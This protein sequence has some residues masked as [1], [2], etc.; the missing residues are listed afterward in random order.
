MKKRKALKLKALESNSR[1][2][3][4]E[5][6]RFRNILKNDLRNEKNKWQKLNLQEED[7]KKLWSK[8]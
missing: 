2:D 3:W 1:E 7:P 4:T 6:K 8:I 5:F